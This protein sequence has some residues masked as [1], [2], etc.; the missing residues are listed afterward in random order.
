MAG[1]ALKEVPAILLRAIIG[2][3]RLRERDYIE[4]PLRHSCETPTSRIPHEPCGFVSG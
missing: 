2:W 1:R 3:R 4:D